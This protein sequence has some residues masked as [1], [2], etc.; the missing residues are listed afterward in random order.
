LKHTDKEW[1]FF[2]FIKDFKLIKVE[3]YPRK[4][5]IFKEPEIQKIVWHFDY[6]NDSTYKEIVY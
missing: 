2:A 4:A 6:E 3:Q 5:H 1:S